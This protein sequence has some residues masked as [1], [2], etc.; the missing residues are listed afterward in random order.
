MRILLDD[1]SMHIILQ[2]TLPLSS[3]SRLWA[4]NR[5]GLWTNL[6]PCYCHSQG[7]RPDVLGTPDPELVNQGHA[8]SKQ[9]RARSHNSLLISDPT[10]PR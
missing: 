6:L 8:M 1:D 9:S 7:N 2:N 3:S 4:G 5:S 10:G